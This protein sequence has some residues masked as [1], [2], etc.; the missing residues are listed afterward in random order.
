MNIVIDKNQEPPFHYGH[1]LI[2]PLYSMHHFCTQ[3]YKLQ[4]GLELQEATK[5]KD[6]GRSNW[7]VFC[8]KYWNLRPA[9]CLKFTLQQ[10]FVSS[11][12]QSDI[13]D[14]LRCIRVE[15]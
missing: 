2:S 12:R 13:V 1:N 8:F 6:D 10:V 7:L 3:N 11:E 4:P 15:F 14:M 5:C 9:I